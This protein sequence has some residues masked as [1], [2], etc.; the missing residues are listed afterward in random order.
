MPRDV[1]YTVTDVYPEHLVLDG[2]HPLAGIALRLQ[3]RVDSVREATEAE[4]AR[5]SLGVGFFR[6]EPQHGAA[7][8]ATLH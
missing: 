2:N 4:H 5:A 3:L 6:V 7:G 8:D 1:R